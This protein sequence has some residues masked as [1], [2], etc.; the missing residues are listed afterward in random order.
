M[1][2]NIFKTAVLTALI[3]TTLQATA[4]DFDKSQYCPLTKGIRLEYA[5][6]NKKGEPENIYLMEVSRIEGVF[7][8]GELT[9]EQTF[10]TCDRKPLIKDN[11]IPMDIK[12]GDGPTQS[13]MSGAGRIMKIQDY[14]SKGDASSLPA[15]LKVGMTIPDGH[16]DVQVDNFKS[17]IHVF[18]RKV[19]DKKEITTEAGTFDCFLIHEKQTTKTVFSKEEIVE[20]WYT[21]GIGVVKQQVYNHKGVLQRTQVLTNVSIHN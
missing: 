10:L 8:K 2:N 20:S 13:A 9:F 3:L 1:K 18:D 7:E 21:K 12:T 15:E 4:Q 17:T 5:N 6:F 19:M 16:I 14:I 11:V